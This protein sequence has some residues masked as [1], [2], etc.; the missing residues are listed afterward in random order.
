[1]ANKYWFKPKW[2]GYGFFPVTW[3]GW[4]ATLVLLVLILLS[5]FAQGIYEPDVTTKAGVQ[6]FIDVCLLAGVATLFFEK[7]MEEPLQWR[8]HWPRKH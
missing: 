2:F 8:W 7:K 4:L 5:A 1:M 3:E 6:F